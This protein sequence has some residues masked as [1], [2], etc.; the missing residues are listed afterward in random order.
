MRYK[1]RNIPGLSDGLLSELACINIYSADDLLER[2]ATPSQRKLLLDKC[3]IDENAL[4]RAVSIS[5]LLR[6]KGVGPALANLLIDACAI[7]SI[8][9]LFPV[10]GSGNHNSDSYQLANRLH[11]VI[12]GYLENNRMGLSVPSAI[13]LFEV[14]DETKELRP[15]VKFFDYSMKEVGFLSFLKKQSLEGGSTLNKVYSHVLFTLSIVYLLFIGVGLLIAWSGLQIEP[16][17]QE[18]PSLIHSCLI[19]WFISMGVGIIMLLAALK[20]LFILAEIIRRWLSTSLCY[21]L[22]RDKLHQ[23]FYKELVIGDI[24][25]V[26]NVLLPIRALFVMIALYCMIICGFL[27]YYGR[28][29][30]DIVKP[31]GWGVGIGGAGMAGILA[32]TQIRLFLTKLRNKTISYE[33]VQRYTVYLMTHFISGLFLVI[34]LIRLIIP[35]VMYSQ[36]VIYRNYLSPVM[37]AKLSDE[38]VH[39][40]SII[41]KKRQEQQRAILEV[42]HTRIIPAFDDAGVFVNENDTNFYNIIIPSAVGVTFWMLII[43]IVALF[44]VPYV[45]WGGWRKALL[46]FLVVAISYYVGNNLENTILIGLPLNKNS[47]QFQILVAF[48]IFASALMFDWI[49][50]VVSSKTTNCVICGFQIEEDHYYCPGCGTHVE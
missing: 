36:R 47:L 26:K 25:V 27:I 33:M 13:Q 35:G 23:E 10:I 19:L 12:S 44:I 29:V 39:V 42:V 17:W 32:L 43:I 45:L 11:T 31:V 4:N 24:E 30:L 21:Q 50:S 40:A 49:Y 37:H 15:R 34:I 3:D 2:A 9:D 48:M 8:G 6:I 18:F 46:Y 5:D 7:R 38:K 1:L 14:I 41:D 28:P 22:F 20:I 16:I